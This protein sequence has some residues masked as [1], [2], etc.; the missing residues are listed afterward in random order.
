MKNG[1]KLHSSSEHTKWPPLNASCLSDMQV[2][3]LQ[4]QISYATTL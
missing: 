1:V 3:S 4:F 2:H